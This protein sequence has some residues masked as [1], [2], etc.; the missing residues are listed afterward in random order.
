MLLRGLSRN[1]YQ[2]KKLDISVEAVGSEIKAI[3][4][5]NGQEWGIKTPVETLLSSLVGCEAAT[6]NALTKKG[7]FKVYK[8]NFV[9]VRTDYD[10]RLF[11]EGGEDNRI[12]E[13]NFETEVSTNGT[14]QE[15]DELKEK[16]AL[17]CPIYQ[18]LIR[19]GVQIK[20]NWTNIQV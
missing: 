15:L 18:T 20:D 11:A 1:W 4:K 10:L 17:H 16:T 3:S 14:Q 9:S 8:M 6:V 12:T 5:T 2:T 13:I 19:A 7:N